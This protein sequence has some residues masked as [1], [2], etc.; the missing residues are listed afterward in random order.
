MKINVDALTCVGSGQCAIVAGDLF[1][2]NDDGFV[3]LLS[4]HAEGRF[5][6]AARRAAALCPA[7]AIHLTS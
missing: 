4:H 7:R 1:D 5:E 3:I 2:Q 6:A